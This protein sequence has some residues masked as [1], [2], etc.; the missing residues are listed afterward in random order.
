[1][2]YGIAMRAKIEMQM[3][4]IFYLAPVVLIFAIL[5]PINNLLIRLLMVAGTAGTY[6]LLLLLNW[7]RLW[8]RWTLLAIPMAILMILLLPELRIPGRLPRT[9]IQELRKY[10]SSAYMPG[11]ENRFG[12]DSS[13]LP[14]KAL[15]NALLKNGSPRTA[16][17]Q[18][19]FDTSAKAMA[20]EAYGF[21]QA[22]HIRGTVTSIPAKQLRPGDLA[23]TEDRTH[24]MVYLG[25]HHWIHADPAV[26]HVII[27]DSR[28]SDNPWFAEPVEIYKFTTLHK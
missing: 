19:W 4:R 26:H 21:T 14:R 25:D 8:M 23:I 5:C 3:R 22:R 12:I 9:F 7:K 17:T 2:R 20:A 10:E 27:E 24:V 1:M 15:R 11:G 6:G 13:G 16:L 18:W 28:K